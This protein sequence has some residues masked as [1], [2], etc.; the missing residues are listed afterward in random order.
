MEM[1]GGPADVRQAV[2]GRHDDG[3]EVA[4]VRGGQ[5]RQPKQ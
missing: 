2:A 5:L 1:Q 4:A 3:K